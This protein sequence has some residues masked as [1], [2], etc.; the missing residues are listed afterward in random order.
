M[1]DS[2]LTRLRPVVATEAGHEGEIEGFQNQTLRPILKLQ[3]G[4]LRQVFEWHI[5][6]HK[7]GAAALAGPDMAR[8]VQASVQKN[9]ALRHLLAGIVIGHFTLAEHAFF[10]RHEAELTR[11]LAALIVRRLQS[12]NPSAPPPTPV[13]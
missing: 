9:T 10:A 7:P 2:E 1:R 4:L 11:R 13:D 12:Q 6:K 3:D 5:Q 8:F